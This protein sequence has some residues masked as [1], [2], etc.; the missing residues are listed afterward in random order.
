MACLITLTTS[1]TLPP[2]ANITCQLLT[3]FFTDPLRGRKYTARS[4]ILVARSPEVALSVSD[5]SR[6]IFSFAKLLLL[7]RDPIFAEI[8]YLIL[9]LLQPS[10]S[11]EQCCQ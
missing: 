9:Q 2:G 1:S 4:D 5:S 7:V 6:Y 3:T 10:V 8:V 11:W